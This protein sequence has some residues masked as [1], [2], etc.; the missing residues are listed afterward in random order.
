MQH[1]TLN[2]WY[3]V[4]IFDF[5][6]LIFHLNNPNFWFWGLAAMLKLQKRTTSC[7]FC[8][9]KAWKFSAFF[10]GLC[11]FKAFQA[12]FEINVNLLKNHNL[13]LWYCRKASLHSVEDQSYYTYLWTVLTCGSQ[14]V[15]NSPLH[16]SSPT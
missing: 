15:S 11:F 4:P 13:K 2:K 12:V 16:S 1:L 8:P 14:I 9:V 3:F 7:A 6:F 5:M 10:M